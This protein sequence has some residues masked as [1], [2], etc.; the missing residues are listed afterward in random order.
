MC[1]P[2]GQET[3]LSGFYVYCSQILGWLP[4][5]IFTVLVEADVAY[6]YGVIASSFGF[7]VAIGLLSC[8]APWDE[9]V[10]ESEEA[11][12]SIG[13]GG[14]VLAPG[15]PPAA[16]DDYDVGGDVVEPKM[17]PSEKIS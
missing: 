15:T 13:R 2:R 14:I 4:P 1:V 9:I 10:K 16:D 11:G 12:D 3:E 8:A 5:L 6:K 17:S 7:V